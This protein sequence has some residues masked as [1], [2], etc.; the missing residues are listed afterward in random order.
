MTDKITPQV[1]E[2][3]DVI[4]GPALDMAESWADELAGATAIPE[5]GMDQAEG[6]RNEIAK[7]GGFDKSPKPASSIFESFDGGDQEG[8]IFRNMDMVLDIPV[9]MSVEVGRCEIPIKNLL[10][11]AQGSVIELDSQAGEP[12]T[13]YVNGMPMAKGE[14]VIV[15]ERYA[16]RLTDVIDP[17]ARL[18]HL[19]G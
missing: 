8:R 5:T 11:L 15:N 18:K 6:I 12:M 19:K 17:Q 14:I 16:I 13:V 10:K 1:E 9:R 7:Q 3:S 2:S 4:D